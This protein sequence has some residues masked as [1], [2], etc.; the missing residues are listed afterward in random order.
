MLKLR[1]F[2]PGPFRQALRKERRAFVYMLHFIL[3]FNPLIFGRFIPFP[4]L[5]LVLKALGAE[6]G[7]RAY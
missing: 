3:I 1:Q 7:R 4:L 6:M 2:H 5:G